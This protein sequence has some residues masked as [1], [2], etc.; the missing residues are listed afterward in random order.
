MAGMTA[1]A[2]SIPVAAATSQR[3]W[4]ARHWFF[5]FGLVFGLWVWLPFLAPILMH[6]GLTAAGR[7]VYF[8]YSFFCHQ[9][10]ERSFFLFGPKLM[11]PLSAL[12]TAGANTTSMLTLRQFIGTPGMGWKIAWSDRMISFYTSIWAFAVLWH[13]FRR[14]GRPLPW[15]A[16]LLLL[17]PMVLDG[18]SHAVSD[19]YGIGQGFRDTNAWLAALTAH[20]FPAGFYAGDALGSFNSWM[21]LLTGVLAGFGLA[22]FAFPYMEA[23]FA[24]G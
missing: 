22:W 5:I 24:E 16:M 17:L 11:Y 3:G 2:P 20:A 4:L 1:S 6:V 18:G 21:R 13:A 10:P 14:T 7:L 19:L 12:Q 8:I 9:L 15:W 23:S